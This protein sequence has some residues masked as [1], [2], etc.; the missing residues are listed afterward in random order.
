MVATETQFLH[1]S[2]GQ[3]EAACPYLSSPFLVGLWERGWGRGRGFLWRTLLSHP[4]PHLLI[5][6]CTDGY[7]SVSLCEFLH[8]S[9]CISVTVFKGMFKVWCWDLVCLYQTCRISRFV[10]VVLRS[11]CVI[12]CRA[13]AYL[14]ILT[15]QKHGQLRLLR[16]PPPAPSSLSAS[17][18]HYARRCRLWYGRCVRWHS[19]STD[20]SCSLSLQLTALY[21]VC[22]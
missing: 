6:L 3:T 12:T 18:A 1:F 7:W 13:E 2:A 20:P 9:S 4:L 8:T 5:Q 10:T 21:G 19:H 11:H 22:Y 15:E 16:S 17:S 14:L